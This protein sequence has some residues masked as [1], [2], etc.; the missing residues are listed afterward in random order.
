MDSNHEYTRDE[1]LTISKNTAFRALQQSKM[2]AAMSFL[3]S[4]K[5][6]QGKSF[7]LYPVGHIAEMTC[8]CIELFNEKFINNFN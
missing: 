5:S 1:Y 7:E 6:S 2:A 3:Q 4:I 8:M